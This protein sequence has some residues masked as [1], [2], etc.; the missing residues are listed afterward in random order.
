MN[1]ML[2]IEYKS[3]KTSE[4]CNFTDQKNPLRSIY[5]FVVYLIVRGETALY[6]GLNGEFIVAALPVHKILKG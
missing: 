4:N 3:Y 6:S 2:Y 5:Y 1:I